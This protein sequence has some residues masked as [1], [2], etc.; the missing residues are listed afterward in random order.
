VRPS[1]FDF[2]DAE[3]ENLAALTVANAADQGAPQICK[4]MR[5][6]MTTEAV[7]TK[8]KTTTTTVVTRRRRCKPQL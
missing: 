5:M 1:L 3:E 6:E 8:T 4:R 2:D 7:T